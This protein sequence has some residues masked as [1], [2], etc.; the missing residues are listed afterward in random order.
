MGCLRI[1]LLSSLLRKG[2]SDADAAAKKDDG[3][4]ARPLHDSV[5][6]ADTGFSEVEKSM[7]ATGCSDAKPTSALPTAAGMRPKVPSKRSVRSAD[8]EEKEF[9]DD[10]SDEGDGET[11]RQRV[12]TKGSDTWTT[13]L[14]EVG[15]KTTC[16]KT[17]ADEEAAAELRR[18]KAEA[19]RRKAHQERD[20]ERDFFQFI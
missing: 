1:P 6:S 8:E 2:R 15:T 5:I 10:S 13:A 20:Q 18:E 12:T 7:L 19:A 16:T 3:F 9:G 11:L 17:A 4:A 14:T